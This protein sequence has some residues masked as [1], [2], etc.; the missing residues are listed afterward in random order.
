MAE[1]SM[2]TLVR[3]ALDARFEDLPASVVHGTKNNLLDTIGCIIAGSS[4]PACEEVRGLCTTLGGTA[5]AS[6]LITGERLPVTLA[7][8]ANGTMARARDM[9]NTHWGASVHPSEYV[10]PA[11]LAMADYVGGISGREFLVAQ[12]V[13]EDVLCRIG[14]ALLRP[15]GLS[16]R[17]NLFRIFG[18]TIATARLEGLSQEQALMA[19]GLSYMQAG[20]EMQSYVDGA[21]SIRVQQGLVCEAAVKSVL[22][23]EAGITGARNILDGK[24]SFFSAF[25]P[26]SDKSRL[27]TDLGKR[28]EGVNSAFKLFPCCHCTHAAI[29]ATIDLV[30]EHHLESEDVERIDVRINKF[31]YDLVGAPVPQKMRPN[32]VPDAQ[33]SIYYTVARAATGRRVFLGEFSPESLHDDAVLDLAQK[34]HPEI[35]PAFGSGEDGSHPAAVV[36]H[37]V[38]GSSFEKHLATAKGD[39]SRPITREELVDKF[40]LSCQFAAQPVTAN[41]S[42]DIA[43]MVLNLEQVKDMRDLIALLVPQ[44]VRG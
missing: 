8:L 23:A 41:V 22:L 28:F 36:I 17:Y 19:M 35:D 24:F 20:G 11:A 25:E 43:D 16:G 14:S 39:P 27:L 34:V 40:S 1:D 21:L 13:G 29:E 44:R 30:T 10:V 7:A 37:T 6:V 15:C 33:F 4:A 9:G 18:P 5:Q 32:T 3:Y 26:E 42:R 12:A 2:G 38:S 31:D